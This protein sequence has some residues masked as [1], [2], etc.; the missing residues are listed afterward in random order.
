MERRYGRIAH[1]LNRAQWEGQDDYGIYELTMGAA[2]VLA[3]FF[4]ALLPRVTLF[5][6][7]PLYILIAAAAWYGSLLE[8]RQLRSLG[9]RRARGNLLL[10]ITWITAGLALVLGGLLLGLAEGMGWTDLPGWSDGPLL[11]I[12]FSALVNVSQGVR[13]GIRRRVVLGLVLA[14][15]AV[16]IPGLDPLRERIYLATALL[17]GGAHLASGAW[18]R[19]ALGARLVRDGVLASSLSRRPG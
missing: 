6:S 18:G 4:F 9:R 2:I 5:T 7:L 17:A 19:R 1:W 15:W 10:G 16:L 12:V 14:A 13:L 8:Q 3:F 11:M